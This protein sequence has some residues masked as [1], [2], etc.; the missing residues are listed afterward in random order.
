MEV[1]EVGSKGRKR[2][3]APANPMVRQIEQLQEQMLRTQEALAEETVTVTAGGGA[4][5]VVMNGQQDLQSITLDP[6]V[7]DPE[8]VEML[9]DLILSAA[10][11]AI[12]KASEMTKEEMAKITGGL[13]LPGMG[14]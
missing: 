9:Q 1:L 4:I 10:N 7:V 6:E 12:E 13:G 14:F 11:Q 5:T 8:D 2:Y 3:R